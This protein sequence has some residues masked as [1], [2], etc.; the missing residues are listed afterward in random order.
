MGHRIEPGFPCREAIVLAGGLGTRLS[1][2][3]M[4]RPKAMIEVG[5]RPF[6]EIMLDRLAQSSVARVILA[7][8]HGRETIERH[9]GTAG[10]GSRSNTAWKPSP[11]EP[12]APCGRR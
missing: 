12:E 3:L 7:T 5:G 10:A 11:W 1:S 2:L 4:D 8:G 9:F 6:L